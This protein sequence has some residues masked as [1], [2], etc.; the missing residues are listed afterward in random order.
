MDSGIANIE[1]FRYTLQNFTGSVTLFRNKEDSVI[2]RSV[3]S[4]FDCSAVLRCRVI[5]AAGEIGRASCRE[6]V[7]L[8]V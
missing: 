3:I 6:R 4:K 5:M 8:S 7:F 2:A 1:V